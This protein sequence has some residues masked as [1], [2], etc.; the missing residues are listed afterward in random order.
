MVC[1]PGA[2]KDACSSMNNSQAP[3][4]ETYLQKDSSDTKKNTTKPTREHL[5]YAQ[6]EYRER[7]DIK[8]APKEKQY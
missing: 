7:H 8:N 6:Q 4:C 2:W 1:E 3:L 5:K